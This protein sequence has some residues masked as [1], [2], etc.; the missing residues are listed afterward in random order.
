[1]ENK[2][3]NHD[4]DE[5]IFFPFLKKIKSEHPKSLFFGQLNVNSI[6][7]NFEPVPEIIKSTFDFFLTCENK[8]DS[9]F[10]QGPIVAPVLFNIFL[11]DILLS[12]QKC[13]LANY[14]YFTYI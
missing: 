8:V 1:M 10:P 5:N 3:D 12:L 13:D 7:N 6:R 4:N 2:R 14:A 11:N 9:F